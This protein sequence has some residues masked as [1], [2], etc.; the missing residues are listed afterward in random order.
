MK[1]WIAGFVVIN[2]DLDIGPVLERSI[3]DRRWHVGVGENMLV[4]PLL[5]GDFIR[6]S[7]SDDLPFDIVHPSS[8]RS[9]D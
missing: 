8:R 1:R 9:I 6:R 5:P 2:F 7:Y 4:V 3:P